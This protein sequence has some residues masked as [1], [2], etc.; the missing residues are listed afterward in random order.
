M[1]NSQKLGGSSLNTY[2][3]CSAED[4]EGGKTERLPSG[5]SKTA[6]GKDAEL[7][8]GSWISGT[9]GRR[10]KLSQTTAPKP[11]S[12]GRDKGDWP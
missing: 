10:S 6:V 8:K 9:P 4:P 2:R 5:N 3:M 7:G 12:T 11:N 1:E